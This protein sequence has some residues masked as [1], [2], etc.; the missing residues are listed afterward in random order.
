MPKKG[1]PQYDE[2]LIAYKQK[3]A[4]IT[5]TTRKKQGYKRILQHPVI[6]INEVGLLLHLIGVTPDS[7]QDHTIPLPWHNIEIEPD[8]LVHVTRELNNYASDQVLKA[9]QKAINF[10]KVLSNFDSYSTSPNFQEKYSLANFKQ[11]Y[12]VEYD[13]V[14]NSQV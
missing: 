7:F 10:H 8:Q 4:L 12:S 13:S 5:P 3:R 1:T 6:S 9:L 11:T 2:W 14:F